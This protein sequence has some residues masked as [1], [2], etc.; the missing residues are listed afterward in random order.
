MERELQIRK[1]HSFTGHQGAVYTL[2][3]GLSADHIHS[4]SSDKM[5]VSWNIPEL[6][7]GRLS[8]E[9]PAPVYSSVSTENFLFIGTGAGSL[10]I[11]DLSIREQI[12]VLQLHAGQI[13]DIAFSEKHQLIIT[14]G[15][16]GQISFN[17]ATDFS[18]IKAGKLCNAKIRGLAIHPSQDL[19]AVA[20]GDGTIRIFYLPEQEEIHLFHAHTD[21]VNCICWSPDGKQLLSGGKD[22][23]LKVWEAKNNF[24]LLTAIPA[25]NFAI[26]K[27]CFSPDGNLFATASRDKTV[28]LWETENFKFLVR[29]NKEV[30]EGHI[31]SVNT[32]L[33][34]EYGLFSAG[35]DRQIIFWE[36]E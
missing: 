27:I 25:H 22:A 2:S 19:M 35:D 12:K 20:C 23:Y 29:I 31:N 4:G 17:S 36:I 30:H 14:A 21:S 33:W 10:H 34:N 28:K 13:F 16:D 11:I 26:Y 15:G 1:K 3:N 5:L 18:F 24:N 9:F 32:I 6:K 8:G 7:S